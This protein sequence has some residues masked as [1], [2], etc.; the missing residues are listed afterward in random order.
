MTEILT[1]YTCGTWTAPAADTSGTADDTSQG[2]QPPVRT[3]CDPA[4]GT[5]VAGVSSAGINFAAVVA[6]ARD[7]GGPAVRALTFHQ[8][9]VILKALAT[10]LNERRDRYHA[11]SL[12]TGATARDGL[13]DI[14]GGISTLFSYSSVARRQ[15]PNSTVYLDG[16]VE[17][18]SK[19]QTFAGQHICTARPGVS[20]QINAFNFPVWGMLEKFG[21]MFAA[22]QPVIV[23]PATN[24]AQL[25]HAVVTDIIESGLL[26]EGALQLICGSTGDLLDHLGEQ[27]T[28]AFTGSAT[29]ARTLASHECVT[30]RGTR[31]FAEADSLNFALLGPDAGPGSEEF[32]LYVSQ[33]VTEMTAKAG[34][35]CTAIRRGLVPADHLDAV[36]EA[37]ARKLAGITVGSPHDEATRMGPL[38]SADQADDVREAIGTLTAAGA[39]LVCGGEAT[40]ASGEG[41]GSRAFVPPTLLKAAAD[42]DAVHEVEAF[43]PVATLVPY[44]SLSEAVEIAA[45]GRGSLVGSVVSHDPEV[46][47]E[48]VLG[49]APW[50]GRILVLDRDDA[51]EST[52]HGSPLP[53]LVHGGPGRA[54]G[55]EELGGIRSVLHYMQRT[56][57][58]ASPDMLTAITGTWAPQAARRTEGGHPFGK[59][60]SQLRIGDTI[61]GGPREVTLEDVDHFAE[62]TGDTFYAHTDEEAAAANPFFPGRVAHGYLVVSFAAGLF[63]KPEPGPVLANYGLE[64]LRFITPVSPGDSLTVTLTAK[65]ITPRETDEYGEVRW[66]ALV[67]NQNDDIVATYD[68]LTLVE[69]EAGKSK[70]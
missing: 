24:G 36:A 62:F 65:Q 30:E 60:L 10:Y 52:G 53:T 12:T 64:N 13:I 17:R 40:G 54:G 69:K 15:M 20:V 1:S 41:T 8:R 68:V 57:I 23:K 19:R 66:D 70:S 16:D 34:Q 3:I 7:T 4:T 37:V 46:V 45:R 39:E 32:D 35:K 44:S 59:D 2:S 56:A 31:F 22:G 21:P 25:T 6:H 42:V 18:L 49:T 55:G 27:D 5:A 67:K 58:Q 43:G 14:D 9:G 61:V 38:V 50:H 29:T 26:P 47:R 63:V 48:V 11:I 33:L 51:K 28:I